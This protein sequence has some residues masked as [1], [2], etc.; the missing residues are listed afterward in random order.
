MIWAWF[1][2]CTCF[3]HTNRLFYQCKLNENALNSSV[4]TLLHLFFTRCTFK[5]NIYFCSN[6]NRIEKTNQKNHCMYDGEMP[7]NDIRQITFAAQQTHTDGTAKHRGQCV[8]RHISDQEMHAPNRILTFH[9]QF[10]SI[11]KFDLVN[12]YVCILCCKWIA[13]SILIMCV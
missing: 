7:F 12:S 11:F 8:L 13:W 5:T 2:I 1:G 3:W 9:H 6:K 10:V 4:N